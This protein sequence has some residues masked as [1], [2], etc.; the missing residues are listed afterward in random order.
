QESAG[1]LFAIRYEPHLA[2]AKWYTRHLTDEERRDE[3][4]FCSYGP[5]QILFAV[6]RNHGFRGTPTQLF[7]PKN[8]IAYGVLHL[9]HLL[10]R[11]KNIPDTVS[12]YNQGSPAKIKQGRNKGLYKNQKYVD[13]V[14]RFYKQFQATLSQKEENNAVD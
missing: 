4:Y 5:M 10:R 12:S 9:K 8:S 7:K 2:R 13:N 6:A 14:L 11:F 3:F 1:N